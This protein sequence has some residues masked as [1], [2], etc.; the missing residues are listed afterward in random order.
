MT[1]VLC[2][3]WE[4]TFPDAHQE[5]GA[6]VWALPLPPL[7]AISMFLALPFPRVV[8]P[9]PVPVP[10]LVLVLPGPVYPI[11]PTHHCLDLLSENQGASLLYEIT[12]PGSIREYV[13]PSTWFSME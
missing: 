5:T 2:H 11:I 4:E 6:A 7:P 9:V 1:P 12:R 10:A 3:R 13:H 8:V